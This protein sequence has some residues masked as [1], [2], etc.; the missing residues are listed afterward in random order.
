[1]KTFGFIMA[2]LG[3]LTFWIPFFCWVAQPELTGMQVIYKYWHVYLSAFACLSIGK[4]AT[5]Q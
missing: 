5:H 2:L 1:M 3:F 4:W